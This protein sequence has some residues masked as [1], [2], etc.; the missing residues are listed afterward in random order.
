MLFQMVNCIPD[1][2]IRTFDKPDDGVRLL[3]LAGW[4]EGEGLN[5]SNYRRQQR[6]GLSLI[7]CVYYHSLC[8][9]MKLLH[10]YAKQK[11][12]SFTGNI[13]SIGDR[14]KKT[15]VSDSNKKIY[16]LRC[17]FLTRSCLNSKVF[18]FRFTFLNMASEV[19]KKC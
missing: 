14:V 6:R 15:L 1:G 8:M 16:R 10:M 2:G 7:L 5:D 17:I 13:T 3:K 12:L 19:G 4:R 18:S 11:N 9:F